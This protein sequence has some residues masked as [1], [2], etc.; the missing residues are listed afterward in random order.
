MPVLWCKTITNM[1]KNNIDNF[2]EVGPGRVLQ[3]LNRRIDRSVKISGIE[4]LDQ[5]TQYV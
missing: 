5:V 4:N 1:I 3:G 2:V